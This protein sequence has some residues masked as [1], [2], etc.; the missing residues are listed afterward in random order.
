[1]KS[2]QRR[3]L[4]TLEDGTMPEFL[5]FLPDGAQILSTH[6]L[7]EEVFVYVLVEDTPHGAH[8]KFIGFSVGDDI[9]MDP[10]TFI[11]QVALN[12]GKKMLHIFELLPHPSTPPTDEP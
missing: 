2:I 10:M 8:R 9:P 5:V 4:K 3:F 11:G 7:K 1:M 12:N 6:V